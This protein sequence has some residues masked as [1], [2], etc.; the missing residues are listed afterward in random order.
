M[1]AFIIELDNRPGMLAGLGDAIAEKGINITGIA[2]GSAADKG[3]VVLITNDEA[4]TRSVL[5]GAG[6]TFRTAE[7]VSAGLEDRPGSLA[8]AARK[9]ADAGV[10]IEGLLPTGMEG[11]K[12]TIAFAVD[13]AQ[14]ARTALG[15]LAGATQG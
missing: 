15:E 6:V 9:L 10:N 3:A 11:G 12:I 7:L 8:G 14:A 5:D 2:G 13:D 1:N 4:G